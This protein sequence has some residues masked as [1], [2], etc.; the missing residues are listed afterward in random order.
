MSDEMDPRKPRLADDFASIAE[1]MQQ[2]AREEGRSVDVPQEAAPRRVMWKL[3]YDCSRCGD[4]GYVQSRTTN[5]WVTCGACNNPDGK[6]RPTT[7]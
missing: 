3:T 1:R 4:V 6:P 2:I 5:R 7:T